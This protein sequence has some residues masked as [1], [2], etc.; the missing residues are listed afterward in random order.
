LSTESKLPANLSTTVVE[1]SPE[2]QALL[3]NDLSKLTATQ[4][5]DLV[6]KV[7]NSLGL[8]PLTQPFQYIQL[9][10]KLTLYAQ[11]N[12][13]DQLRAIKSVSLTIEESKREGDLFIVTAR[14]TLPSGRQDQS[15]GA[16]S[17]AGLKNEA[18]AN[19]IMKAETKAKRRVT[20]SICGLS[21]MDETE[22]ETIKDAKPLVEKLPPR[23]PEAPLNAAA[24]YM[25]RNTPP[26]QDPQPPPKD[27]TPADFDSYLEEPPFDYESDPKDYTVTVG[28]FAGRQLKDIPYKSLKKYI[29]WIEDN[30]N[31]KDMPIPDMYLELH[32]Q[33]CKYL[34]SIGE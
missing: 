7:C 14:A 9:N 4:R 32:T 16:V 3:N 29:D 30:A 19:A 23:Q 15:V 31:L 24:E 22:V 11:R 26:T 34:R 10:G 6:V 27:F 28:Q 20:L 8:N 12:C 17:L 2:E 13:T 5:A 33:A 18:L 1:L 25:R 21:F